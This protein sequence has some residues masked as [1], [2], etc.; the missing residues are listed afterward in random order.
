VQPAKKLSPQDPL[1]AAV[2]AYLN[3]EGTLRE[4]ADKY[5][6]HKTSVHRK[7]SQTSEDYLVKSVM[8]IVKHVDQHTAFRILRKA[9]NNVA[10]D[11]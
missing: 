3:G 8:S 10:T 11:D 2:V 1:E 9:M 5:G 6:V 4:V 7:A